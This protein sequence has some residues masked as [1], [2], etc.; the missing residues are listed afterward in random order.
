ML[1][2]EKQKKAEELF[3]YA[4][5][6][7]MK[8]EIDKAIEFFRKAIELFP[9][10]AEAYNN[11][12]DALLKQNKIDEAIE[13][14]ETSK[15][16]KPN[17]QNTYYDLGNCY[18]LK[19]NYSKALNNFRKALSMKEEHYEIL[20]KIGAIYY[21]QKDFEKAKSFLI[22]A[23]E[24]DSEDHQAR[25]Y[26]A[27]ICNEE[28]DITNRDK[29]FQEVIQNYE[30]MLKIKSKDF[31]EARYFIGLCNYYMEKYQL[32]F[33]NIKKAIELDSNQVDFHQ[34]F[35]LGYSDA[36]AFY[37]L[38][39]TA[40]KLGNSDFKEKCFKKAKELE[41]NNLLFQNI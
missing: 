36:E 37:Y 18:L 34:S 31:P 16:I 5:T 13:N 30:G 2:H 8:G 25:F 12:G 41:P 17:I 14:Y 28:N 26:L 15:S 33:D 27:L 19:K 35:G 21:Y 38:G 20:S 23:L 1:L 32:A 7:E 4:L 3:D 11:L 39:K 40:E 6:Y 22:K 9:D 10:F 24:K 29:Y